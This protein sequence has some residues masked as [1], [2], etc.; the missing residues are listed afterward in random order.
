MN[1]CDANS[2]KFA[3]EMC[4]VSGAENLSLLFSE[5]FAQ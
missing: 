1:E 3:C 4:H 5:I 2:H